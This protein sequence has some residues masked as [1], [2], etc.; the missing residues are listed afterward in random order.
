MAVLLALLTACV[1]GTAD[2]LGGHA[3]KRLP[4]IVVTFV[5]QLGGLV[6]LAAAAWSSGIP[7]PAPSDWGWSALAGLA[8][9]TGLL[10]FYTAM[11]SG[12]MTV[13]APVTAVTN[14]AIPV[15]VGFAI[16][17]R[18]GALAL[19]GM[20][21]AILAVALV[22]DVLGPD[23]RRA[24]ARVVAMGALGGAMFGM[25][26]VF[27]HQTSDGSGVW[28]VLIMRLV[29]TPYMALL[30]AARRPSFAGVG[31]HKGLVIGSGVLDSLANWLYV[32]AVREGLL[33]VVSVIVTLY[34]ATTMALAVGLDREKVHRPQLLGIGLAAT[35][36]VLITLA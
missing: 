2:Y 16:G 31:R 34:P 10:A 5:G 1:Y 12:Y 30:V 17:E 14:A 27:L 25:I 4:A 24:P 9:S 6:I 33:S 13:V 35:A 23:H 11:S 7:V 3:T 29:S 36:L 18:P 15:I 21:L 26:L 28:P 8:G 22:S 19:V 20:P 32:L